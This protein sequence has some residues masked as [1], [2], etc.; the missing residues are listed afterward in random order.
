[1]V[2]PALERITNIHRGCVLEACYLWH[3]LHPD[4]SI[5]F[6]PTYLEKIAKLHWR[7]KRRML[8]ESGRF[9]V[10]D[11]DMPLLK[12]NGLV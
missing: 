7:R 4:G 9:L 2:T 8:H 6:P 11:G 1:M 12:V 10:W 5:M 3:S